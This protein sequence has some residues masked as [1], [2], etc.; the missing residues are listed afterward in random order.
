MFAEIVDDDERMRAAIPEIFRDRKAGEG[1][2]PLQAGRGRGGGDNEDATLR[3]AVLPHGFDH[4]LDGGRALPYRNI[5]TNY[6]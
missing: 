6:V 3:R 5:D 1:G 4:M 2:D